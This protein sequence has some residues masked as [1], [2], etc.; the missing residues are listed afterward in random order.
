MK[1]AGLQ[2]EGKRLARK[3]NLPLL[4]LK[5]EE[6]DPDAETG[7]GDDDGEEV[8]VQHFRG[9]PGNTSSP[10]PQTQLDFPDWPKSW[11]S[12]ICVTWLKLI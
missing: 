11:Q 10:A 9:S 4:A 3:H 6:E 7:E 8:F 2:E 12:K 5:N 1:D